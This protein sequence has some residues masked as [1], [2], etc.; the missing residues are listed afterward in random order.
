M[1]FN[2]I[3]DT[4]V[5]EIERPPLPPFGLY[6]LIVMKYDTRQIVAQS[7]ENAGKEY[8]VLEFTLRGLEAGENVD[9]D[10][11]AE[12]GDPKN[13]IVRKS[14]MFDKSDKTAFESTLANVRKFLEKDLALDI[15]GIS[16]KEALPRTKNAVCFGD[17]Q[18]R[19]DKRDPENMFLDLK[20]TTA[21]S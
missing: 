5:D 20:S 19:P 2:D 10:A 15:A 16:M 8:D 3:L 12:Y 6:K 1:N 7:G 11:L 17:I 14:F 13:I 21:V 9:R 18:Y 4:K